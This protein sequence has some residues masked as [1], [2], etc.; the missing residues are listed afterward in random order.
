[1]ARAAS[2]P[3]TMSPVPTRRSVVPCSVP[4]SISTV[5]GDVNFCAVSTATGITASTSS[6]SRLCA[7][8]DRA[9]SAVLCRSRSVFARFANAP[10]TPPP[11][12]R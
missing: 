6:V 8:E 9:L 7:V 11:A 2:S 5:V 1:M 10:E 4:K 12:R 3:T